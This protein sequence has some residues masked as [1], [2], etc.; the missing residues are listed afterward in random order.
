MNPGGGRCKRSMKLLLLSSVFFAS[1]AS[2]KPVEVTP[3]PRAIK[4]A[5]IVVVAETVRRQ[6]DALAEG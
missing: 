2:A 6:Y 5:P 3:L 4:E 1:V